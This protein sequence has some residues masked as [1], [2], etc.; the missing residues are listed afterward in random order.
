MYVTLSSAFTPATAAPGVVPAPVP[1][2]RRTVSAGAHLFREGDIATNIYEITAGVFRLT[3]VLDDGRRQVIAFGL[4]GDII[5]FPNGTAHHSDC[6][7]IQAGAV[8]T[9]RRHALNTLEGDHDT[10]QRLL[11]AALREI[12]AMQDH[13]MMLA[14]KSALEKVASFLV[15]LSERIGKSR[16]GLTRCALPMSRADIADFLG[17]TI[18]TVSRTLT[19]LRKAG[20]IAFDR[21]QTV[22]I[23]DMDA[24]VSAAQGRD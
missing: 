3:R 22:L 13:L 1:A 24:L 19:R 15:T 21:A 8:I 11:H 12:S 7:A 16:E 23:K 20:V 2:Q 5:G 10:H 9:H 14:R 6:E 4:P 18:E 17:L